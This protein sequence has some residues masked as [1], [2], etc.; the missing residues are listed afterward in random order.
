M[1]PPS[2]LP[3]FIFLLSDHTTR[4]LACDVAERLSEIDSHVYIDDFL[5]PVYDGFA[6][7]FDMDLKRDFA[8]PRE[9][10][11]LMLEAISESTESDIIVSLEKWFIETFGEAQ[12]GRMA[13]K[14]ALEVRE[15]FDHT[16]VFRDA[17]QRH[18]EA[19]AHIALR[20][21]ILVAI[22][23]VWSVEN[24]INWIKKDAR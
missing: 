7:M 16:I 19:F 15:N 11:K 6:A 5:A 22:T 17:T 12:L 18:L 8:R 21:K 2:S 9:T 14:R 3:P 13:L 24:H 10:D 1:H 23:S 20:D 4:T